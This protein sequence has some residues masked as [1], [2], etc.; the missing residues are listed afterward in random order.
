MQR[1]GI[2][3]ASFFCS[4]CPNLS[5]ATKGANSNLLESKLPP[6]LFTREAYPGNFAVL[7]PWLL[8]ARVFVLF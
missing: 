2:T 8:L 1:N 5:P 4:F 7:S 6:P 3:I